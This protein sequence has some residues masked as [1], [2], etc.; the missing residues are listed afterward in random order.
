MHGMSVQK[1]PCQCIDCHVTVSVSTGISA[2]GMPYQCIDCHISTRTAMS[3]HELSYQRKDRHV[4]YMTAILPYQRKDCHLQYMDC[5]RRCRTVVSTY[6]LS[7]LSLKCHVSA[8]NTMST[9]ELPCKCRGCYVKWAHL[10]L[11]FVVAC[12]D[13]PG[14]QLVRSLLPTVGV[15]MLVHI[16]LCH[17][18]SCHVRPWAVVSMHWSS[19]E[20][21]TSL[22]NSN[23][24]IVRM[25]VALSSGSGSARIWKCFPDPKLLFSIP[26]IDRRMFFFIQLEY[27]IVR[28]KLDPDP[29]YLNPDPQN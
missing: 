13:T 1:L 9:Q 15:N 8:R 20:D 12:S 26:V 16:L 14:W 6:G 29:E 5:Q 25:T 24:L 27:F 19:Y 7:L 22:P 10:L 2:Q 28:N 21:S 11:W 17:C 4:M 18:T 23:V 3:V